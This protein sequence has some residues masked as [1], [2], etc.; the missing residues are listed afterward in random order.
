MQDEAMR[1]GQK[2]VVEV[3]PMLEVGTQRQIHS[4]GVNSLSWVQQ[5]NSWNVGGSCGSE[6]FTGGIGPQC[7]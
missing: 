5:D 4:K 3:I 6:D 7:P 2:L 1:Q